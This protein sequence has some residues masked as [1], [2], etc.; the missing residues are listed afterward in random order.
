MIKGLNTN[1]T[2]T[3]QRAWL[4]IALEHNKEVKRIV[5]EKLSQFERPS[6]LSSMSRDEKVLTLA[7]EIGL[8]RL[9]AEILCE[10]YPETADEM[11]AQYEADSVVH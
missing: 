1:K 11:I 5:K 6:K 3:A 9:Y 8:A 2:A 10:T 4:L 7:V